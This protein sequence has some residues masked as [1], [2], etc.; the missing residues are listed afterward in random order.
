MPGGHGY[1]SLSENEASNEWTLYVSAYAHKGE[2]T[3]GQK[4]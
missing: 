3:I 1:A 2:A 4:R